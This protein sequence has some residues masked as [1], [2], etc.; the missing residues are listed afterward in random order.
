MPILP[1]RRTLRTRRGG[2]RIT[3]D[4]H[5]AG[6]QVSHNTVAKIMAELGIEGVSPRTFKTTTVVDPCASFPP[7]LVGRRFDQGRIDAVWS[8]DITYLSCGEGDM[9]LCAIRDEHSRRALGWAVDD[10]MRTELVTTAVDRAVF[11]RG[12]NANGVILH[13]DR[14]TQFT[15]H[16]M[17][18]AAAEHGLRRSM[19]ATGICLLTG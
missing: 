13:S 8:T 4:L 18:E 9:F 14:G 6:D 17:A 5:E 3:A 19:G 16:G 11:T 2:S 15:S 1:N 12:G 10:H 7:D